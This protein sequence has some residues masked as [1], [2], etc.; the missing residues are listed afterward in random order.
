[1]VRDSSVSSAFRRR[2]GMGVRQAAAAVSERSKLHVPIVDAFEADILSGVL[3]VGDRIPAE[4]EIARTFN[5]STRIVREA[6]QVLETKGLVRRKHGERSMVVREDVGE[7]LGTLSVTVKQ[8]FSCRSDYMVQLMDVRRIIEIEVVGRLTSG[9]GAINDEV[10][11][12]LEAMRQA[13]EEGDF[14]RFTDC[15]AAFHLGLVHSV[16]NEILNVFYDNLFALIIEVIRLSSRIPDKSLDAGYREHLEIYELIRARDCEGAK[17]AM[18]E[19]IENSTRYLQ[20]AL[21]NGQI[22]QRRKK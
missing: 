17:A 10:K 2:P 3:K 11:D 6:I 22:Q 5:V 16:G 19:Q 4:G 18:R 12:A 7:F 14:S 15:D 1:M 21:D 13:A 8:L 20:V 9:G